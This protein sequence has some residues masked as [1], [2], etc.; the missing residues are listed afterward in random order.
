MLADLL[1]KLSSLAG[2]VGQV[3]ALTGVCN[4]LLEITGR[5]GTIRKAQKAEEASVTAILQ[6]YAGSDS[7]EG[8]AQ[9]ENAKQGKTKKEPKKRRRLIKKKIPK[10]QI[11][12]VM[13]RP[14][15]S[16]DDKAALATYLAR[17]RMLSKSKLAIANVSTGLITATLGLGAS[18]FKGMAA[19]TKGN[20]QKAAATAA[21]HTGAVMNVNMLLSTA[22]MH[23]AGKRVNR[24]DEKETNLIKEGLWGAIHGLA[25]DKFGLRKIAA[26]L[27]PDNPDK[28]HMQEA[29]LAMRQYESASKHLTGAGV[30]FTQLFAANDLETFKNSLVAGM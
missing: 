10:E 3:S 14:D 1:G 19:N 17:E 30:N 16:E 9:P 24:T 6:K 29:E 4:T 5:H 2:L 23:I 18:V 13:E 11:L 15:V 27:E 12:R 20:V 25:D 21:A 22:G 26:T 28:G 7:A 8:A